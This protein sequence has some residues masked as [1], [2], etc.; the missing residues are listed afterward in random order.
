MEPREVT[1]EEAKGLWVKSGFRE[2]EIRRQEAVHLC[3]Y[4]KKVLLVP[5][6]KE[7]SW[8]KR[9][10]RTLTE[11]VTLDNGV[12]R[13]ITIQKSNNLVTSNRKLVKQ[14]TLPISVWLD[15]FYNEI[16]EFIGE[17]PN[18]DWRLDWI[19]LYTITYPIPY[20]L[21]EKEK[22]PFYILVNS[23]YKFWRKE[24]LRQTVKAVVKDKEL[25]S[26]VLKGD[27]LPMDIIYL[28]TATSLRNS[29]L[30]EY[31]KQIMPL[32]KYS[33]EDIK[34]IEKEKE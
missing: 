19:L 20:S 22:V 18:K 5:P 23:L 8:I 33:I 4:Y 11:R 9:D 12:R 29:V 26:K 1:S 16:L 27:I 14:Y 6:V 17:F 34:L 3:E 32:T 21:L 15:G 24:R 7:L 2:V 13:D 25:L 31:K 10:N 28:T 30:E